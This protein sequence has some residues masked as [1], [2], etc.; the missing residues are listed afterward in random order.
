MSKP[1]ILVL[2]HLRWGFV[3]QRPQ[4]LLSRLA[5][6][7]Q[8]LYLEEPVHSEGT[9]WLDERQI[10][11]GLTVLV[12]HTPL[13]STGFADDQ[14]AA[15]SL[16]L[17]SWLDDEALRIDVTWVYTPMAL[18]LA[19]AISSDCLIYDCMDEL[20]SFKDAPAQLRQ[21]E[22]SLMRVADLV[23]TGGPSLFQAKHQKNPNVHCLPSAVDAGHFCIGRL[24]PGC[25]QAGEADRLQGHL[26]RP[27][28]GFFGVIDERLDVSLLADLADAHPE[29]QIV[30]AGPVVKIDAARLPQR[31]NIHWLGMQ[32]YER[33]PYLLAGWDLCLMPFALNESTRFISPTKTLEYM[34]GDK[35]VIST[36]IQD[37]IALYG[38]AVEVAFGGNQ[39]FVQACERVLAEHAGAREDRKRE[40]RDAVSTY[41]WDR[42]ANGVHELLVLALAASAVPTPLFQAA[43]LARIA[44]GRMARTANRATV[45]ANEP[46]AVKPRESLP[47]A[48]GLPAQA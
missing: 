5:T 11:P 17:Q 44:A 9:A 35:P 16:L 45:S 20:A 37:V 21:R 13:S 1:V 47:V 33:L 38:K 46:T 12:P 15:A 27:R 25:D 41:S 28:L 32:P 36:P 43:T 24:V 6:R 42:S 18:P 31:A 23:L 10:L 2:S 22:D 39:A 34:A 19:E 48:A 4:H 26:G 30:M 14:L 3:Y 7:W 29:W 40:M 8:V